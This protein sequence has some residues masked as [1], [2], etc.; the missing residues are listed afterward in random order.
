MA[1]ADENEHTVESHIESALRSLNDL[2]HLLGAP[3]Y[4]DEATQIHML[5]V[6]N[7]YVKMLGILI[8]RKSIPRVHPKS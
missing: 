1:S 7:G 3:T 2:E 8:E 6:I 5:N 4:D